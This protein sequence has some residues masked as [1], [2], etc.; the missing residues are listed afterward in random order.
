MIESII[1][2]SVKNKALVFLSVLIAT[3]LSVWAIKN[4]PLDA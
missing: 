3:F 1:E 4:T 2:K